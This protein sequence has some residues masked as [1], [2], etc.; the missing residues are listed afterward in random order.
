ML[1]STVDEPFYIPT[2]S[3]Q[4]FRFLHILTNSY[5]GFLGFFVSFVFEFLGPHLWHME[6]LRLGIKSELQLLA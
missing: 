6:V 3:A 4:E 1:F 2:S 5:L